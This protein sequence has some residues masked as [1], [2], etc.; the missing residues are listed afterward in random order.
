ML[1]K[2]SRSRKSKLDFKII[3]PPATSSG[4]PSDA[5]VGDSMKAVTSS[6]V[7]DSIIQI[8]L[9]PG[10]HRSSRPKKLRT[11]LAR[12][13]ISI[14]SFNLLVLFKVLHFLSSLKLHL[15]LEK[16]DPSNLAERSRT[17]L[18][19]SISRL[20]S[21]YRFPSALLFPLWYRQYSLFSSLVNCE[22]GLFGF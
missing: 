16:I 21:D 10:V 12:L 18:L 2:L 15:F 4:C 22:K 8:C 9:A 14:S 1:Y 17:W 13:A 19:G 5:L 11:F 7:I 3:L 20:V 6:P